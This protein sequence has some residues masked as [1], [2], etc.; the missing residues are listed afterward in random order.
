MKT[1]TAD[2]PRKTR[3]IPCT[4][5][6]GGGFVNST[7]DGGICYRCH[8]RRNDP[9]VYDWTYP[10][11]WT[12]EQIAAFLAA[13]DAK[14]AARRAKRDEKRKAAEAAT[15]AANVETCPALSLLA[16]ADPYGDLVTKARRY[17]MTEK[18]QAYAAQLAERHQA[19]KAREQEA[20]E[21]RAAGITVPTGKQTVRG[22]VAGFKTQ[23]SRYGTTEKMIVRSPEGWAVYVT[24]PAGISPARGDAVEFAA[25]IERSDRD[26]LFGF[27]KRPTGARIIETKATE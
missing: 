13:E 15:W 6:G 1:M 27:G 17:T 18:Q 10:A 24:V 20:E 9:T 21:R 14:A 7:V 4:R 2:K 22:I 12:A 26:P 25:T 11:D 19:A 3:P 5:C 16:E 8:G 23:E